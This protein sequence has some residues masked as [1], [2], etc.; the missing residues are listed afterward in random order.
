MNY[1]RLSLFV[2]FAMLIAGVG[3]RNSNE[4]TPT[5]PSAATSYQYSAPDPNGAVVANGTL[6]LSFDGAAVTGYRD[7]KGNVPEAGTG[8]ANGEIMSDGTVQIEIP[9]SFAIVILK[10]KVEGEMLEGV[11]LLDTG[12]PPI[13]QRIGTFVAAPPGTGSH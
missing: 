7:I 6:L 1:Q 12:D 3:C 10:G 8:S 4:I 13:D 2:L 5:S 11:R 9:G